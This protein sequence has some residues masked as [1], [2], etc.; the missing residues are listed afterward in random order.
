MSTSRPEQEAV[1]R[2]QRATALH[3]F[4]IAPRSNPSAFE[5]S[6][7]AGYAG[8]E[9]GIHSP[10]LQ[11]LGAAR[12]ERVRRFEEPTLRDA[13]RPGGIAPRTRRAARAHVQAGPS[14]VDALD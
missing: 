9:K 12:W 6:W 11:R 1:K 8:C 2:R 7:R 14:R 3:A 4:F 10:A 5:F 13:A